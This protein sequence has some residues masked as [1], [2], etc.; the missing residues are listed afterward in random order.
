MEFCPGRVDVEDDSGW[1][2]L[3]YGIDTDPKTV[4]QMIEIYERRG[5]TAK[6]FVALTWRF[7]NN[8]KHLG[9]VLLDTSATSEDDVL[10]QGLKFYPELRVWAEYY[11]AKGDDVYRADFADAWTKVMNA[12][13]FDGP[14]GNL[15]Y[16]T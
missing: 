14:I 16:D 12:D 1:D 11:V 7:Y 9:H 2:L 15:C 8:T 3:S 13:R 10:E 6:E 5:Q 4:D